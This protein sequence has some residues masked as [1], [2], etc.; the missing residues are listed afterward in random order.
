MSMDDLYQGP[1]EVNIISFIRDKIKQWNEAIDEAITYFT[2]YKNGLNSC[3]LVLDSKNPFIKDLVS[4]QNQQVQILSARILFIDNQILRPLKECHDKTKDEGEKIV[5]KISL[6]DQN[7]SQYQTKLNSLIKKYNH[8]WFGFY[9]L[10]DQDPWLVE[11]LLDEA[12]RLFIVAK[13][14]YCNQLEMLYKNCS[15]FDR[16]FTRTIKNILKEFFM[17]QNQRQ[18]SEPS[19][20]FLFEERRRGNER[21]EEEEEDIWDNSI[22]T[23]KLDWDWNGQVPVPPLDGFQQAIIN[24]VSL[25][26][27]GIMGGSLSR[28]GGG[29][30][31][32][33]GS[34]SSLSSHSQSHSQ[35][36]IYSPSLSPSS[37]LI[38]SIRPIRM[39]KYGWLQR[40]SSTFLLGRNSWVTSLAIIT[41]S[42]FLHLYTVKVIKGIEI[43]KLGKKYGRKELM[44]S[45]TQ[46]LGVIDRNKLASPSLT[47]SL[48][49]TQ[50]FVDS[51]YK[52]VIEDGGNGTGKK[53]N[54]DEVKK[55]Q[56]QAFNEEE[57][58]D[59]CIAIKDVGKRKIINKEEE[60]ADEKMDKES[61]YNKINDNEKEKKENNEMERDFSIHQLP[62][63]NNNGNPLGYNNQDIQIDIENPWG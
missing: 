13:G 2:L 27:L 40:L 30:V 55:Y 15:D 50:V 31:S 58:V 11:I 17:F 57:M 20:P 43:P 25:D 61:N 35:S 23:H 29:S 8:S 38:V 45:C 34:V 52:I 62:F 26:V 5:K 56:L 47:I 51:E 1:L 37:H 28:S 59:W 63:N 46:I 22:K 48:F 18:H 14:D 33:E 9:K 21:E 24:Q 12:M 60:E 54:G 53:E 49:D 32:L 4:F 39:I 36:Q 41:D 44:D 16:E 10:K 6:N 42:Q 19:S 7:I 3:S